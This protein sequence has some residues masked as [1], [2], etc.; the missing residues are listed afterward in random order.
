MLR[1]TL[2][3]SNLG[4]LVL[5]NSLFIR[6]WFGVFFFL[7]LT[8]FFVY[9]YLMYFMYSTMNW[10]EKQ[11]SP[12]VKLNN[13][14]NWGIWSSTLRVNLCM[15]VNWNTFVCVRQPLQILAYYIMLY[16]TVGQVQS[17]LY[18][19]WYFIDTLL[20]KEGDNFHECD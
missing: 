2:P 15:Q 13:K 17:I 9:G 10:V 3:I 14:I 16:L 18:T 20:S 12:L 19:N 4:Y 1:N 8:S 11:H 5:Y 7:F 6:S